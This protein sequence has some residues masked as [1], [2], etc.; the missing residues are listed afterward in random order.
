MACLAATRAVAGRRYCVAGPGW[1]RACCR[2]RSAAPAP[3]SSPPA[4]LALRAPGM[5]D[6]AADSMHSW[7]D[8]PEP[9]PAQPS[10][11]RNG[12]SGGGAVSGKFGGARRGPGMAKPQRPDDSETR[13]LIQKLQE[14]SGCCQPA[15]GCCA[16][17]RVPLVHLVAPSA[18]AALVAPCRA[19]AIP[20]HPLRCCRGCASGEP[21][22]AVR[23]L[24]LRSPAAQAAGG[25]NHG[26]HRRQAQV[27]AVL[28][29][30]VR[31]HTHHATSCPVCCR[32]TATSHCLPLSPNSLLY[33]R[34]TRL[35]P[36]ALP[37]AP[38]FSSPLPLPTCSGRAKASPQQA[39]LKNKLGELR[40]HLG[41]LTVGYCRSCLGGVVHCT[42]LHSMCRLSRLRM[43][44]CAADAAQVHSPLALPAAAC[45]EICNPMGAPAGPPAGPAGSRRLQLNQPVNACPPR[46]PSVR[47]CS[48]SWM[49]QRMPRSGHASR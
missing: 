18:A 40:T 21:A 28:A 48:R 46:R 31:H 8:E 10:A 45:P 4:S 11:H 14:T 49:W 5:A 7:A 3:T 25:G 23:H 27:G 22:A 32:G 37:T 15:C 38:P 17:R 20:H 44:Q 6:A 47:R 39:A 33:L 19:L 42:W 16:R 13:M 12:S 1:S 41:Q 34:P 9:E 35:R 2:R 30:R 24:M 36:A 29:A 26:Q 43:Q